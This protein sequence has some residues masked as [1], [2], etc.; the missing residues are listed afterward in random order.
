MAFTEI[1]DPDIAGVFYDEAGQVLIVY[2]R[3]G[4]SRTYSG[5]TPAVA[6]TFIRTLDLEIVAS[7]SE[8]AAVAAG[9]LGGLLGRLAED[10]DLDVG[11]EF[12]SVDSTAISSLSYTPE[13]RNLVV[14]FTDGSVYSYPGISER[15]YRALRDASSVGRF[16]NEK[17]R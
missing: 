16:F 2:F 10:P 14:N 4:G 9:E 11:V 13:I 5:I 1:D 6:A 3:R 15:T 8:A 7:A 12:A 17:I